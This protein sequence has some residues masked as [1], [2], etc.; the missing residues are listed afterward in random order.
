MEL[1]SRCVVH[2]PL[3]EL[4]EGDGIATGSCLLAFSNSL[5]QVW[6]RK[7]RERFLEALQIFGAYENCRRAAVSGHD[8]PIVLTLDSVRDLREM[9]LDV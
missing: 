7:H 6:I 2:Q 9:G 3:T 5:H 8:D 1:C 4:I